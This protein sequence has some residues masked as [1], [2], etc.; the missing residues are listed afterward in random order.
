MGNGSV[1]FLKQK[2]VYRF[3]NIVIEF[4]WVRAEVNEIFFLCSF[5]RSLLVFVQYCLVGF[6]NMVKKNF[7]DGVDFLSLYPAC[8]PITNF[9]IVLN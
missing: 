8:Y 4:I 1:L 2:G 3:L 7:H 6:A 5:V 9:K